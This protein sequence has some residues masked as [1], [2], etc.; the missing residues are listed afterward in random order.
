MSENRLANQSSPYLLQHAHNPVDWFPWGDDAFAEARRRDVP[1]FLSIGYSTCYW[2]HVMERESFEDADIAAMLNERFVCIKVDREQRPDV[3]EIYM[4]ATQLMTGH[5]GWPMSV[6]IDPH[7]LRPF[8]CGTYF[9]AR[10]KGTMNM[11]TFPHVI[12]S[13]AT[14]W[15]EKREEV[16]EQAAGLAKAVRASLRPGRDPAPIGAPHVERAVSE[17][18]QQFDRLHGGFGAA[19]KFPQ[20]AHLLFLLD[21]RAS[22]ADDTTATAID[23]VLTHTLDRMAVGG[24]RDQLAGGFHRYSVDATWTVPHFEKMLYDNALLTLVYARSARACDDAF[25]AEVA[26]GTAEYVL[27]EMTTDQGAFKS[28]QDAEVDGR[29]GFNYLWTRDEMVS[30]LDDDDGAFA[31][32]VYG[33][34]AGPNFRDPHHPD[35]QPRNV[36]RL[37][38]RPERVA[39]SMSLTPDAFNARLARV[40]TRLL[41]HRATRRA[42]ITDDKVI[43][44]WNGLMIE[45]LAQA[46]DLLDEPRFVNAAERAAV[47]VLD[48]MTGE[49][50]LLRCSRLGHAHTSGT[51]E[52]YACMIRA[53]AAL[54][55][56]GGVQPHA[57]QRYTDAAAQFAADVDRLFT[58]ADG[59]ADSPEDAADLFVRPCSTYDGAMPSGVSMMLHALIDLH[60]LT[61]RRE[62]L[63][64]ASAAIRTISPTIADAPQTVI[65]SVAALFRL[66]RAPGVDRSGF[67]DPGEATSVREESG[68]F[69]PVEVYADRDRV[70]LGGDTPSLVN[71][72]LRIAPGHHI[73]AAD[74]GAAVG[75]LVPLRVGIVNGTGV[76]VYADYPPGDPLDENLLV[77]TGDISMKVLLEREG[78]FT[79]QPLLCVTFQACTDTECLEPMTVE[80][81]VAIDLA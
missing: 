55:R 41:D 68:D 18:L 71:I 32:G 35:D 24:I 34:D 52:D 74:P 73:I 50:E 76:R 45:A 67:I 17:L 48:H 37:A 36:L 26:R 43:A 81:D 54:A 14:A 20:P 39:R 2:C 62:Y 75:P 53:L 4:T 66:L 57:A 29:E 19:P 13:I 70:E 7:S 22:T 69:T 6:F 60:E 47:F 64:R 46:G 51:L 9:P 33:L 12:E 42:P 63:D 80:L 31:S 10:A 72:A 28:A 61:G 38:D 78:E 56:C 8:W 40:N 59:F 11:P 25:Y 27:R 3:D 79:G 77:H 58:D 1:I 16:I 44:S 23:T 15:R 65:H 30:V 49:G 21:V 5:G